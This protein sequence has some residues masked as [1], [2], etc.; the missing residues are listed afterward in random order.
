MRAL[1]EDLDTEPPKILFNVIKLNIKVT[2]NIKLYDITKFMLIN[3]D[4]FFCAK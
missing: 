4:I 3:E 2:S 1:K